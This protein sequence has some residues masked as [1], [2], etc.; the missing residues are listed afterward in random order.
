MCLIICYL[1]LHAYCIKVM[2]IGVVLNKDIMLDQLCA[3]NYVHINEESNL[4]YMEMTML[5][6]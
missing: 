5:I 1:Y 6:K 2:Q 4:W 3:P